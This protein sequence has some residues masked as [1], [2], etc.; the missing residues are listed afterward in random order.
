MSL[1]ASPIRDAAGVLRISPITIIHALQKKYALTSVNQPLLSTLHPSN[2]EVTSRRVDDAEGN[3]TWNF[4]GR[5]RSHGGSGI[6]SITTHDRRVLASVFNWRKHDVFLK[7]QA[8][9]EPFPI[10]LLHTN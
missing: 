5:N 6:L 4:V 1:N 3:E 2:V 7:G 8:L 10:R 9:L